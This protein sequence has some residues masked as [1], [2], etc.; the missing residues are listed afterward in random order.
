MGISSGYFPRFISLS[1]DNP[2]AILAAF[3][4]R[5]PELVELR[6][7]R[8]DHIW[9]FLLRIWVALLKALHQGVSSSISLFL[10]LEVCGIQAAGLQDLLPGLNLLLMGPKS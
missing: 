2:L 3:K 1:T 5:K 9:V 4:F 7:L 8:E 10:I 6:H